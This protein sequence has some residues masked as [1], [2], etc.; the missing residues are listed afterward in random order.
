MWDVHL[1]EALSHLCC[2]FVI[3]G[4]FDDCRQNGTPS[5]VELCQR[6]VPSKQMQSLSSYNRLSRLTSR[7][8]HSVIRKCSST[9]SAPTPPVSSSSSASPSTQTEEVQQRDTTHFGFKTIPKDSKEGL[10]GEVFHKVAGKYDLM[11]D[12][13]SLGIHRVWK[14]DF[15]RTLNPSPGSKILDVAGGTGMYFNITCTC[16]IEPAGDIAF[17]CIENIIHSPVF[18]PRP[19]TTPLTPQNAKVFSEPSCVTVCDIN[20]A[21]LGV[22]RERAVQ[23]GYDKFEGKLQIN[24]EKV[25][26]I[27]LTQIQNLSGWKAMQKSYLLLITP[28]TPIQLLLEL[29]TVQMF[30]LSFQRYVQLDAFVPCLT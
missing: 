4:W 21:M 11:N 2:F 5:R 24:L 29:E 18:F 22:G 25:C 17:R 28:W 20:P 15:I 23:R 13:M 8:C 3:A 1:Q 19:S 9:T 16:V 10:V 6:G 7:V 12:V 14:D 27:I 30:Q 26:L